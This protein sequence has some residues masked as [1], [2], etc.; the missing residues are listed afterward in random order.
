MKDKYTQ[1]ALCVDATST[2]GPTDSNTQSYVRKDELQT[3]VNGLQKIANV[4]MTALE[5]RSDAQ[6]ESRYM[7]TL[8]EQQW[9]E[10]QKLITTAVETLPPLSDGLL[11]T[12]RE[13]ASQISESIQKIQTSWRSFEKAQGRVQ[14]LEWRIKEEE[15][16]LY[17]PYV[18]SGSPAINIANL[19][20]DDV[21][22]ELS[23]VPLSP[24]SADSQL[25]EK[26]KGS[27][28]VHSPPGE[29]TS[30]DATHGESHFIA[31]D[32]SAVVSRDPA[33]VE[34]HD[35]GSLHVLDNEGLKE[36]V[37]SSQSLRYIHTH[38]A[39][40]RLQRFAGH[41]NP[42]AIEEICAEGGQFADEDKGLTER[43]ASE[44]QCLANLAPNYS[45]HRNDLLG[46]FTWATDGVA[47]TLQ[48]R[49]SW[50]R[51]RL[52]T[53][54][55]RV[56]RAL[57]MHHHEAVYYGTAPEART[58][59]LNDGSND[60]SSIRRSL[61]YSWLW[62]PNMGAYAL[63]R[64]NSTLAEDAHETEST[65]ASSITE[66]GSLSPEAASLNFH[67]H[68][69]HKSSMSTIMAPT[70]QQIIETPTNIR[71]SIDEISRAPGVTQ[72]QFHDS[73][74]RL[75][76]PPWPSPRRKSLPTDLRQAQVPWT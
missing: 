60:K 37:P 71:R 36:W 48:T 1:T 27:A 43:Q 61:L 31:T 46:M 72:P 23:S 47:W 75:S 62:E 41:S 53:Y 73:T 7:R 34:Q 64:L 55:A 66:H 32:P 2:T 5:V 14:M 25:P 17:I 59:F 28:E 67:A 58:S 33:K 3:I 52:S 40:Q 45:I 49:S 54:N 6:E 42:E 21:D 18:T 68:V 38:L 9:A 13:G 76:A 69:P 8:Y 26:A 19:S 65:Q 29:L 20:E 30:R 44:D 12:L 74:T 24:S 50:R 4:R 15:E 16:E 11:T 35:Y 51:S 70:R 10:V 57:V 56:L 63:S 22:S 39:N